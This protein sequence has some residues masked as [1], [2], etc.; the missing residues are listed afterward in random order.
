VFPPR[1]ENGR[2]T[3]K[4]AVPNT[5]VTIP[6]GLTIKKS[7]AM[8]SAVTSLS[9]ALLCAIAQVPKGTNIMAPINNKIM[10]RFPMLC[11]ASSFT[12]SHGFYD[13]IYLF[14]DP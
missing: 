12:Q 14:F 10:N 11:I 4:T 13:I 2:D 8:A 9:I 3:I 1:A 6:N 7:A 5:V